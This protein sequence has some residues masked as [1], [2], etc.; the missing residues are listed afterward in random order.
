MNNNQKWLMSLFPDGKD[1]IDLLNAY[2]ALEELFNNYPKFKQELETYCHMS[3]SSFVAKDPYQTSFNEGA[4]DVFL[5]IIG[6]IEEAKN[7]EEK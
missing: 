1:R 5:H 2:L 6:M 3:I 7:V 4:R